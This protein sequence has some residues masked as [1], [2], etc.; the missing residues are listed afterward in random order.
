STC[1]SSLRY[2][3]NIAPF[4]S[5]LPLVSRLRPITFN[6]KT[7]GSPDIGFAAEEV[8]KA[9]PLLVTRNNNGVI[10]GVK[11]DRI[12]AVLVNAIKE[13]QAQIEAQKQQIA[14]L[15]S[16]LTALEQARKKPSG[17]RGRRRK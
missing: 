12:S 4:T 6:W 8:E 14:A 5:G 15:E 9:E 17:K 11:Y 13:Q 3:S 16:R 1:S 2:K 7:D 10:E